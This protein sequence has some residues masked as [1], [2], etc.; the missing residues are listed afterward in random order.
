MNLLEIEFLFMINFDLSVKNELYT[1]YDKRLM[2]HGRGTQSV[3]QKN[4]N[5][6]G[7]CD[8]LHVPVVRSRKSRKVQVLEKHITSTKFT[9]VAVP[10]KNKRSQL[11]YS[12]KVNKKKQCVLLRS[13]PLHSSALPIRY[14]PTPRCSPPS[15]PIKIRQ[16]SEQIHI[17]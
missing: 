10:V 17:H 5:T 16:A 8:D 11:S 3:Q 2:I 7:V 15:Y 6:V 1:N 13:N 9:G 12:N 4:V 14:Y